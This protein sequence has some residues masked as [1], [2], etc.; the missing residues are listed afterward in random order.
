MRHANKDV[1]SRI[2]FFIGTVA[3]LIKLFPIMIELKN[4]AVPY[5]I[6]S[7]GQ[8]NITTSEILK[9]FELKDVHITLSNGVENKSAIRLFFWFLKTYRN[10]R[11]RLLPEI[12]E[13][14]MVIIHGDTVS[15][16]MGALLSRKLK[17]RLIHIEAG[18]RSYNYL[19][20]FPEEID[21]VLATRFVNVAFCPNGWA[22]RNMAKEN[23]ITKYS[24]EY[25]TLIDSL[26]Y[27]LS[28]AVKTKLI[29][30]LKGEKYFIFVMHRNENLADKPMV[31]SITRIVED[32][33]IKMKCLFI[34]HPV[35]KAIFDRYGILDRI[36]SN[37]NIIATDRLGYCEM[38]NILDNS[39]Y[40]L[41][42]GGS[43]QEECFY[44]GIPC[45]ILRKKTERIEGI[46]E[47]AILSGNNLDSIKQFIENYHSY[48]RNKVVPTVIPSKYIANKLAE[49]QITD[50]SDLP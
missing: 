40:I 30:R 8:N 35:T 17:A 7:S 32:E 19:N 38:V 1:K 46:G 11:N 50:H 26:R 14:D 23:G 31:E 4:M 47:N 37:V 15:T 21:R 42:D 9:I 48:K 29:N 13:G 16:V 22:L 18:L 41:T 43:N 24:T 20:P 25:N 6:I 10:S 28:V 45:C 39:Q 34:L 44:L 33:A 2:F 3:E 5:E 49:Y 27:G 36:H 12:S